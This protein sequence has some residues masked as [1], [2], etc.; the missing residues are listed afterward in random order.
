MF[1]ETKPSPETASGLA[2]ARERVEKA[3][4]EHDKAQDALA[5]VESDISANRT[6]ISD[7]HDRIQATKGPTAA[8]ISAMAEVAARHKAEEALRRAA[9]AEARISSAAQDKIAAEQRREADAMEAALR[10]AG[11]PR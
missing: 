3:R 10:A 7:L 6:A 11:R 5:Q 8:Q 9:L 1:A 2:R 4:A